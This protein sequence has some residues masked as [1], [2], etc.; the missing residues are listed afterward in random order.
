MTSCRRGRRRLLSPRRSPILI[1]V[2]DVDFRGLEA[3]P[4]SQSPMLRCACPDD[5]YED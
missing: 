5:D 1:V 2:Y 3:I 4:V